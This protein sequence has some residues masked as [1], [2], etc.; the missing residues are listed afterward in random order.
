MAYITDEVLKQAVADALTARNPG[1]LPLHWH[2]AVPAANVRA[3]NTILRVM[4]GRGFTL[5][6]V[7]AWAE[8]ETWNR[9]LGVCAACWNVSKGDD[10]R[11]EPFRREW[12]FLLKELTEA[13][14]VADGEVVTPTTAAGRISY[15]VYD[16]TEDVHTMEDVL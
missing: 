4:L 3:Y 13:V 6:Q 9:L 11:G 2:N 10:D 16:T 15:G 8:R 7:N 12:E 1:Q 5:A 14:F